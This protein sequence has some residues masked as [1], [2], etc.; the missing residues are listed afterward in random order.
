MTNGL[1]ISAREQA[2]IDAAGAM[3]RD[4]VPSS[5]CLPFRR[6]LLERADEYLYG[7]GLTREDFSLF[8]VIANAVRL[9]R[10]HP[11]SNLGPLLKLLREEFRHP[12]GIGSGNG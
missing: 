2:L 7:Y 10:G 4:W 12:G 3:V 1:P 5:N 9:G 11:L 6:A 8:R